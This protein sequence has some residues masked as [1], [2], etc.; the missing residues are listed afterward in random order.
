MA[1]GVGT[2]SDW[3]IEQ[4]GEPWVPEAPE[5]DEGGYYGDDTDEEEDES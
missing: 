2:V 3:A 4:T 5:P 1:E